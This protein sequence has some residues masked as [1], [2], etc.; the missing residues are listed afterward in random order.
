VAERPG[1]VLALGSKNTGQLEQVLKSVPKQVPDDRKNYYRA[2][3]EGYESERQSRDD[4][5]EGR[6]RSRGMFSIRGRHDQHRQP[7]SRRS[8]D[9]DL[10]I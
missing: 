2:Q 6:S 4:D 10:H 5:A 1:G 7:N 8:K 3:D 9:V